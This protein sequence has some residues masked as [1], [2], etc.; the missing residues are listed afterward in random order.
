[1]H[2]HRREHI[3]KEL[4]FQKR[5]IVQLVRTPDT[6]EGCGSES[7]RSH[8]LS[9]RPGKLRQLISLLGETE[10]SR[11]GSAPLA[12]YSPGY[13]YKLQFTSSDFREYPLV[14]VALGAIV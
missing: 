5:D 6:Q 13:P 8:H 9:T 4:K 3:N 14:L 2:G 11:K 1:M 7:R 10:L 12:A